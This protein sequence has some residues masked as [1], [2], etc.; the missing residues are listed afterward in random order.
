MDAN[1]MKKSKTSANLER[2]RIGSINFNNSM[3]RNETGM[4][5]IKPIDKS[6]MTYSNKAYL[7]DIND[8]MDDE[9]NNNDINRNSNKNVIKKSQV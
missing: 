4:F 6:N 3:N 5:Y 2:S 1:Q 9:F 7:N 8:E